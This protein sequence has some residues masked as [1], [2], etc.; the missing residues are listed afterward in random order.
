M[1]INLI[2]VILLI[3]IICSYII[4]IGSSKCKYI[5]NDVKYI[6]ASQLPEKKI[7]NI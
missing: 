3:C 4:E 5:S 2:L 7:Q 1:Y 6:R